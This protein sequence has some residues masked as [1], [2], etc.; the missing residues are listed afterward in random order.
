[1]KFSKNAKRLLAILILPVI[2]FVLLGLFQGVSQLSYHSDLIKSLESYRMEPPYCFIYFTPPN[3][4]EDI[5]E[6]LGTYQLDDEHL[7]VFAENDFSD[8]TV[9]LCKTKKRSGKDCYKTL[10]IYTSYCDTANNKTV[11]KCDN[12]DPSLSDLIIEMHEANSFNNKAEE[13]VYTLEH[14]DCVI[15]ISQKQ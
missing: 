11:Y 3:G 15:T 2:I 4:N 7:I 13:Y 6:I 14:N 10:L 8:V 12:N 1:M 5:E 9:N